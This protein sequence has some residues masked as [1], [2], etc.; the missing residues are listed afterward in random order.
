MRL[1]LLQL[2]FWIVWGFSVCIWNLRF[3]Y[4]W[5][6]TSLDRKTS[7]CHFS[8]IDDI[9]FGISFCWA[10]LCHAAPQSTHFGCIY[11][12]NFR[13]RFYWV[14]K[15]D[16]ISESRNEIVSFLQIS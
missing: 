1:G 6:S 4:S 12:F 16:V 2:F 3:F 13:I 14:S 15:F 7:C 10:D 9:R 5:I 8:E 11:V